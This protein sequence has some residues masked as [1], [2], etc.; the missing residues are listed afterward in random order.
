MPEQ[1]LGVLDAELVANVGRGG[2]PQMVGRERGNLRPQAGRLDRLRKRVDPARKEP[3][4]GRGQPQ[5]SQQNQLGLGTEPERTRL[6]AT[7]ILVPFQVGALAVWGQDRLGLVQ[8]ALLTS[9]VR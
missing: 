3:G 6:T 1:R 7:G 2:V 9:G 5:I 8:Q 4:F